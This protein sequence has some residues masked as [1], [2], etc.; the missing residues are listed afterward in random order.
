MIAAI[1]S[2]GTLIPIAF[3]LAGALN[4]DYGKRGGL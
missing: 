4:I 2:I 1:L 3:A